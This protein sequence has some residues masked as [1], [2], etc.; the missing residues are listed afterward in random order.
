[1]GESRETKLQTALTESELM[2]RAAEGDRS[3][4]PRVRQILDEVPA[5]VDAL[6]NIEQFARVAIVELAVGKHVMLAE[7]M[8]RKLDQVAADIAGTEPSPL[9]RLLAEQIALCWQQLRFLEMRNAQARD[10]TLSQR[11]H[12]EKCI[13][14][15]QK[16]Y[17][18]A[19]K[20]LAHIRK[21]GLPALQVNIAT[22]GGKQVNVT[23][24]QLQDTDT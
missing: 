3:V 11:D 15:A 10:C 9:E 4:L 5:A 23:T 2:K 24:A 14:R 1:M 16:R 17:L 8:N 18:Q 6:G 19:I 12:Y 21:L 7:A 22:E 13:S 20:T